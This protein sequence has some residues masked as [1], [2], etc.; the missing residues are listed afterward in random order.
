ML[1][2]E[3]ENDEDSDIKISNEETP[4]HI[5]D[6]QQHYTSKELDNILSDWE[7][8]ESDDGI[9][10]EL[11]LVLKWTE[12]SGPTIDMGLADGVNEGLW[13]VGQ[14]EKVKKLREKFIRPSNVVNLQVPKMN[15]VIWHNI[16]DKGKAAYA[17]VQKAVSRF[18]P[19]LAAIVQQFELIN[20]N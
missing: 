9:S 2:N 14:S 5:P 19:G 18:M 7:E 1:G 12:K 3:S 8:D 13:S 16:S 10:K 6:T 11:K 17:V 20:K 4:H 15:P